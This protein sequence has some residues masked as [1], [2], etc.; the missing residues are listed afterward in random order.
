MIIFATE[1]YVLIGLYAFL[2]VLVNLNGWMIIIRQKR[3]KNLPLTSFYIF[4]YIAIAMR[5]IAL[6]WEFENS[7]VMHIISQT[8]PWAKINVGIM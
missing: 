4:A 3:F 2:F 1:H 5:L 6:V 8:V 7:A